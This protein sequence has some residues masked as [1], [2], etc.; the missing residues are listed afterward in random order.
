M[1]LAAGKATRLGVLG[2]GQPK[3]MLR[4]GQRPL[5]EWTIERL[6]AIGVAELVINVHQAPEVIR[7]HFGDGSDWQVHIEYLYEPEPLGTAGGVRNAQHLL[8]DNE[9][10]LVIHGDTVAD[11][12]L[13]LA[14]QEHRTR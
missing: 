3:C 2:V 7:G 12:D 14:V 5:L 6:S 13:S 8:A 9:P 11:W 4:L 1:I 10:F